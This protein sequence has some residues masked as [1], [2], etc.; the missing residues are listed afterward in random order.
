M[1]K[2]L[3]ASVIGK[4]GQT[5]ALRIGMYVALFVGAIIALEGGVGFFIGLD[6]SLEMV[7]AG[8]GI[9]ALAL[10]AKA[11]QKQTEVKITNS[12]VIADGASEST[13]KTELTSRSDNEVEGR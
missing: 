1:L 7:F 9:M 10:G 11:W 4:D 13:N 8:E 2:K 12:K 6:K 5:S 3:S